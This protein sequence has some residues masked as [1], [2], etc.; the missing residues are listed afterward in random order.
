VQVHALLGRNGCFVLLDAVSLP[1]RC[2][3]TSMKESKLK[4]ETGYEELQ[5]TAGCEIL[6]ARVGRYTN[7]SHCCFEMALF[8]M[9][10]E[11]CLYEG[12]MKRTLLKD[13]L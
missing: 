7:N 1:C 12:S 13:A 6:D 4:Y 2:A 9:G 11:R 8:P 10:I 3:E 5:R